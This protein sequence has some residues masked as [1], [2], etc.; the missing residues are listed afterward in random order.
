MIG[1]TSDVFCSTQDG[2]FVTLRLLLLIRYDVNSYMHI[3]CTAKN[4]LVLLLLFYRLFVLFDSRHAGLEQLGA[5][6]SLEDGVIGV[7]MVGSR[8]GQRKRSMTT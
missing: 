3:L 8:R 2:P 6:D 4:S 5:L 7:A 1:I